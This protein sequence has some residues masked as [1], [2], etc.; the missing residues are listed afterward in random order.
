MVAFQ[1]VLAG[2][3]VPALVAQ[4]NGYNVTVTVVN[5]TFNGPSTFQ[6]GFNNDVNNPATP[7]VT[8]P[9]VVGGTSDA[10]ASGIS[11]LFTWNC[12]KSQS[13]VL[14]NE[15]YETDATRDSTSEPYCGKYSSLNHPSDLWTLPGNPQSYTSLV[16][17]YPYVSRDVGH[18]CMLR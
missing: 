11:L 1:T 4:S 14:F 5:G 12:Q 7:R 18:I 17:S 3:V 15:T 6:L 2:R 9:I 10:V 13:F 8:A 16:S